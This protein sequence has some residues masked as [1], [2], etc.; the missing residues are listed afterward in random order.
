MMGKGRLRG[1]CLAVALAA[2]AAG[3]FG[4]EIHGVELPDSCVV[5]GK[6]LRLNGLGARTK[7][8]L[9]VRVY[10][11]GLYLEAPDNDARRIIAADATRRMELRMT[12]AAPRARLM[13]ELLD[14][15][16]RNARDAMPMLK[17]RLDLFLAGIPDLKEGGLLSI[18]YVPGVG[19]HME[20]TGAGGV[21]VPGKDFADALFSAW[22]GAHPLDDELKARLLG[23]APAR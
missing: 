11:A 21:T 8:F 23:A 7:T 2:C 15:I 1:V 9:N 10:I 4:A 18:T 13:R 6:T 22:L 14:G 19:T 5:A 20:A 3:A 17:Q 16:E 12:H